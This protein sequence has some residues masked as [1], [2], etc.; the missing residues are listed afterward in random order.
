MN[1]EQNQMGRGFVARWVV[2]TTVTFLTAT[3]IAFASMWTIGGP[4]LESLSASVA[5][6]ISGVW[7]GALMGLGLGVGQAIALWGKGI[8]PVRWALLSTLGGAAGFALF[9]VL[10]AE[11]QTQRTLLALLAGGLA[12][13]GIGVAQ[14]SLLR[15]RP[16][17]A[18]A[19]IPVTVVAFL[20]VALLAYNGSEGSPGL[21]MLAMGL[22]VAA[23]TGL[24]AVWLFGDAR[25]AVAGQ[26]G[27]L[28]ALGLLL[29]ACGGASEPVVRFAEPRDGVSVAAP[30]RVVM[31]AENFTVEPVGD[32]AVNDGAGHLHIMVNTP[33]IAAGQTI[34]KDETHLH[35][36][37]GSMEAELALESGEHTLCL[38]A[39][40]GAHTALPGEGMTHSITVTVP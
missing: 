17:N 3:A 40:D 7:V 34:P 27:V 23:I 12:G 28:L 33:C 30:V 5:A 32:G 8:S 19:W 39:A 18:V 22:A 11:G 4:L 31:A 35:F 13:L 20:P 9:S 10:T 36:G 25:P 21:I 37:D 15:R 38:Q 14:W 24:G 29:A 16:V 26:L 1:A 2:I 6:V